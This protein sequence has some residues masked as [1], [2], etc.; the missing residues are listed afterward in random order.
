MTM[1][2]AIRSRSELLWNSEG[3]STEVLKLLAATRTV[4]NRNRIVSAMPLQILI[5]H[6]AC[7]AVGGGDD[8]T[9]RGGPRPFSFA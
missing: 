3:K 1:W 8:L 5:T 4:L 6:S 9:G 2:F 7:E